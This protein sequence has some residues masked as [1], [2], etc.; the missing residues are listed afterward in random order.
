MSKMRLF[1]PNELKMTDEE[2]RSEL[3]EIRTEFESPNL[4]DKEFK[5]TYKQKNDSEILFTSKSFLD[6][7]KFLEDS[8]NSTNKIKKCLK[9]TE[10]NCDKYQNDLPS[11]DMGAVE[12]KGR[13]NAI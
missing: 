6:R 4:K 9:L 2:I 3:K 10:K 13:R 1:P 12:G 8:L 11:F 7:L 5:F